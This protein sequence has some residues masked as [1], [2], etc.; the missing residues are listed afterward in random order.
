MDFYYTTYT[1]QY[2]ND[3]EWIDTCH[4]NNTII[5]IASSQEEAEDK[6]KVCLE[7]AETGYYR[8]VPTQK[9]RKCIGIAHIGLG[10][11]ECTCPIEAKEE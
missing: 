2:I 1:R 6:I 4:Q 8:A 10:D 11:D 7:Q 9:V 5:V 3:K